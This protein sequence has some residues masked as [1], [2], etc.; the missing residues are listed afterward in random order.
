MATSKI[1]ALVLCFLLIFGCSKDSSDDNSEDI[2]D[3]TANLKSVG[4]SAKDILSDEKYTDIIFDIV[5]IRGFR[6]TQEAMDEFTNFITSRT[7]KQ[8]ITYKYT[9][10]ASSNKENY[11]LDD[12]VQIEKEQRTLYNTKDQVAIFIFFPDAP[13]DEDSGDSFTLGAAF[14]N[15]SLV[16]YESTIR[17]LSATSSTITDAMIESST[18]QHELGHILGLVNLGTPMV[19]DHE[20]TENKNHCNIDQCLMEATIEF[21]AKRLMTKLA[22]T[23]QTPDL[24]ANCLADLRANGGR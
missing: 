14:R 13:S 19:N 12:V 24:D 17:K 16:I 20:D 21:S 22:K 2:I 7:F 6:P 9:E 18:L 1:S 4:V 23:G 11:T 5:A 10:I 8:N 3:K 15:T